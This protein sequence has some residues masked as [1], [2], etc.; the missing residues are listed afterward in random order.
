MW[1]GPS[2]ST[3]SSAFQQLPG[4][5]LHWVEGTTHLLAEPPQSHHGNVGYLGWTCKKE[6]KEVLKR[7]SRFQKLRREMYSMS[8]LSQALRKAAYSDMKKQQ[9]KERLQGANAAWQDMDKDTEFVVVEKV[10]TV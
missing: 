4:F 8:R 1:L 7:R 2:R 3:Y 9:I 10:T 6:C 5:P